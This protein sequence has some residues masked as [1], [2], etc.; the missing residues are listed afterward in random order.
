LISDVF[1]FRRFR[2]HSI[3]FCN[4]FLQGAPTYIGTGADSRTVSIIYPDCTGAEPNSIWC[5]KSTFQ[6]IVLSGLGFQRTIGM[7]YGAEMN[8]AFWQISKMKPAVLPSKVSA[9]PETLRDDCFLSVGTSC[10]F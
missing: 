10:G 1:I 7:S 2:R 3:P 9:C 5:D 4:L 6:Y 8:S